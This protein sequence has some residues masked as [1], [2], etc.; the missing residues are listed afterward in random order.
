M[1]C[2]DNPEHMCVPSKYLIKRFK[3]EREKE[4]EREREKEK[5]F[6]N[7][8]RKSKYS[9]RIQ[10]SKTITTWN[11]CETFGSVYVRFIGGHRGIYGRVIADEK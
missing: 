8:W 1:D 3:R 6:E 11:G 9:A 10:K 4:R 2:I 7:E 5:D